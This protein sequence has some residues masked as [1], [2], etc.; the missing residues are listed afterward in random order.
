MSEASVSVR[1]ENQSSKTIVRLLWVTVG[2]CGLLWVTVGY[3]GLLWVTVGT[4][5]YCGLLWVTFCY[6]GL[7]WVTVGYCWL[8]WDTDRQCASRSACKCRVLCV[9][10]RP[11]AEDTAA[12]SDVRSSDPT[13]PAKKEKKTTKHPLQ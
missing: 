12:A 6:C 2:Y 4:V 13:S 9:N 5:G 3:Y 7:P 1:A 11:P 10:A 8:L